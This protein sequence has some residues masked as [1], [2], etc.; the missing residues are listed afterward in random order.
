MNY[1]ILHTG[2]SKES[3][4]TSAF[5]EY[6]KRIQ[7]YGSLKDLALKP[8]RLSEEPSPAEIEK[9]LDKEAEALESQWKKNRLDGANT[10][11]IALCI[12][13]KLLSSEQLSRLLSDAEQNGKSNAVF[14]I[15]SSHGL[16]PRIKKEC[17]CLSF[18]PMTFPHQLAKV[19][20]AEQIYRAESIRKGGKYH[21]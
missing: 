2:E 13:G 3:Y 19:M 17:V 11:K 1:Y 15:G 14:L 5:E 8:A 7:A 12:E 18:S 4:W 21:K 16:S 6:R 10:L 20:L 9:A